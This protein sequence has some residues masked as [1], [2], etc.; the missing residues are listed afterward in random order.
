MPKRIPTRTKK[1]SRG[2]Q[3]VQYKPNGRWMKI[4]RGTLNEGWCLGPWCNRHKKT[5]MEFSI[6]DAGVIRG[7]CP[8]CGHETAPYWIGKK[9]ERSGHG[10][11]H[12]WLRK[13][14]AP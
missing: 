13:R 8:I 5:V 2:Y 9:P 6:N 1:N 7:K 10:M 4:P 11:G 12:G 14:R 3:I